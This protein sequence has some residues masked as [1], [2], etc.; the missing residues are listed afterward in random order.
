MKIKLTGLCEK[1]LEGDNF[2]KRECPPKYP[3]K[4]FTKQI[5]CQN[6]MCG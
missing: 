6:P 2:Y 3:V 4:L 5:L 1:I